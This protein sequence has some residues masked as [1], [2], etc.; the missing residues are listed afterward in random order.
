[1][2]KRKNIP[3]SKIKAVIF[4]IG[5]VLSLSKKP[6]QKYKRYL[7]NRGVHFYMAKKLKISLDQYFDSIDTFYAKSITGEISEKKALYQISKNLKTA[8]KKL[9]KYYMKGY[10]KNFKINK[11]LYKFAFQLKEKGYKISILS[12]QWY[13]SKK[14]HKL[15]DQNLIEKFDLVILSCDVGLRKPNPKI[16]RVVLKKLKLPAKNCLFIDNQSWNI[17]PAKKLGMKT[18]LFKNNKQLFK[19]LSKLGII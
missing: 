17:K 11:K 6:L 19:Q 10:K 3:K 15:I 14:S 2:K 4:D 7:H 18:I 16:Y 8:P 12:D 13:V 5:G 9:I 1:M